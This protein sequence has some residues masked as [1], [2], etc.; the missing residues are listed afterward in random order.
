VKAPSTNVV[1]VMPIETSTE[2][3]VP[4]RSEECR[5]V[6]GWLTN[7]EN[8]N[9]VFN[10]RRFHMDLGLRRIWVL[11]FWTL[12]VMTLSKFLALAIYQS[13]P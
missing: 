13:L 3:V 10:L 4:H 2:V 9:N 7:F 8:L 12:L 5:N 11:L 1:A 6:V